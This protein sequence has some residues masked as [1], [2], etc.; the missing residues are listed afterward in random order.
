MFGGGRVARQ[1]DDSWGTARHIL[2][3]E[4]SLRG[5]RNVWRRGRRAVRV[6]RGA[7][8]GCG[9]FGGTGWSGVF[10][11]ERLV[12]RDRPIASSRSESA[13]SA[14]STGEKAPGGCAPAKRRSSR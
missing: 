11:Q 10:E 14:A 9:S 13:I 7:R 4:E 6:R 1:R 12:A 8:Y 2:Y 3:L 5:G